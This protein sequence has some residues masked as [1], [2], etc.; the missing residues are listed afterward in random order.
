MY[1][2]AKIWYYGFTHGRKDEMT[3]TIELDVVVFDGETIEEA[4]A[5]VIGKFDITWKVT[6][7][8][9]PGGGH[10][11]IAFSGEATELE[12]LL[13]SYDPAEME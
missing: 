4:A 7:E 2:G 6:T 10:P 11:I 3:K 8:H 9:G 13:H 1:T 5:A 12:K